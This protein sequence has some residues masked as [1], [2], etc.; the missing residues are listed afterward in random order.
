MGVC[1]EA[2]LFRHDLAPPATAEQIDAVAAEFE[3]T[4]PPEYRAFLLNYNGGWL[5]TP[6]EDYFPEG[7]ELLFPVAGVAETARDLFETC[8]E[9]NRRCGLFPIGG[10]A[11]ASGYNTLLG[12]VPPGGEPNKL[13]G[14]VYHA[15]SGEE[16]WTENGEFIEI[17]D[18]DRK[19]A[20]SLPAMLAEWEQE[21]IER[22]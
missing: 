6:G 17:E 12:V 21:A 19:A 11:G 18:W 15:G 5:S 7:D 13:Y 14:R 9:S 2:K 16:P 1:F 3:V 20:D 22:A 10:L 8:D 4:F